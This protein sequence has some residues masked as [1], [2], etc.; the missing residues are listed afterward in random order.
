MHTFPYDTYNRLTSER[1]S[2]E[3]EEDA[4]K[5][6]TSYL[7]FENQYNF[8]RACVN[9]FCPNLFQDEWVVEMFAR[10]NYCEQFNT[11]PY[12][13]AYDDQPAAWMDFQRLVKRGISE[14]KKCECGNHGG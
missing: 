9:A 4:K 2:I 5:L 6:F 7:A 12:P 13:G 11:Q 1:V 3:S 10:Y 14:V 8:Y